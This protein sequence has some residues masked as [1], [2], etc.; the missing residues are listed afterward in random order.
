[1]IRPQRESIR[2][3]SLLI[4]LLVTGAIAVAVTINF[5]DSAVPSSSDRMTLTVVIWTL[6]MG[7]MLIAGAFGLWA[8]HFA[9]EAESL[10]RISRLVDRMNDIRDGIIA[11]DRQ[12][13]VIGMN[14]AAETIFGQARGKSIR[15]L[16]P[17]IPDGEEKN[18][19]HTETIL[20]REYRLDQDGQPAR[21]LRFRIQPPISGLSL[22]LVSDITSV[23][24]L[25][26]RQRR[27]ASIQLAGHMAQGI[28]NDFNDLLCGISGHATLLTKPKTTSAGL[29]VSANAI[30]QCADRGIRLARQLI[31]L[32]QAQLQNSGNITTQ[33]ARHVA[34]GAELLESNLDPQWT[35]EQRI[36]TSIPPV[37]MPPSQLEHVIHSLGLIV[38]ETHQ[39]EPGTL[40]ITLRPLENA[41]RTQ[42]DSH[43]SA[44][45]EIH[46]C[47][48]PTTRRADNQN[49]ENG[50]ISSLVQTLVEQAGGKFEAIPDGRKAHLFRIFLPEV[51]ASTLLADGNTE[52]T[53]A[54]GLEAYTAGWHVLLAIP[55][56]KHQHVQPYLERKQIVVQ[57]AQDENA[58]LQAVAS[59][60]SHEVIFIQPEILGQHFEAIIPIVARVC[61]NAAVVLL[62]NAPPESTPQ[63]VITLDPTT[64]PALW[65]QAM[66]DARSR[67][68]MP[69]PSNRS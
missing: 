50:V 47:P 53:L 30:Q 15:T 10:R 40:C 33:V 27:A 48:A 41:E 14:T 5:L 61:P 66:I 25:R 64:P 55:P 29:Q 2:Y 23:A 46:C 45:L 37:N 21:T 16:C 63:H 8:I 18:L 35:L 42:N 3:C 54:I 9:T 7:F 62:V 24:A 19:L 60:T 31:Q 57:M 20:E 39:G 59:P 49:P 56:G 34:N 43:I 4:L 1:M 68:N 51:D 6:T 13:K 28:A 67:K 58:F 26:T 38:V 22:L 36:D 65:I 11:I 12:G 44:V 69:A 32:S 17:T 52:E